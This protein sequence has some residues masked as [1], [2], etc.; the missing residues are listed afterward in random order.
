MANPAVLHSIRDIL[1]QNTLLPF[2]KSGTSSGLA[3]SG[4][5]QNIQLFSPFGEYRGKLLEKVKQVEHKF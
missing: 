5:L 4:A 3:P 2:L 1:P